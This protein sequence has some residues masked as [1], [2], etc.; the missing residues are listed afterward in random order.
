MKKFLFYISI[1]IIAGCAS[2]QKSM[3]TAAF[4]SEGGTRGKSLSTELETQDRVV[5]FNGSLSI[6][7]EDTDVSAEKCADIAKAYE[8][9]VVTSSTDR[10]VF[11]VKAERFTGAMDEVAKLGKV[12]YRNIHGR[13]VTEQYRDTEIRL[14]NKLKAR[15]RY[16]QLLARAETVEATL[17][18]EKELERLN[19]EIESYKGRL[20]R[21]SHLASYSTIT[22]DFTERTRYGPLGWVFYGAWHAIKWLFVWE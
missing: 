22:V 4:T 14:E 8:G 19:G 20:Q 11:R 1:L 5:I 3:N 10:V 17:Q 13:D 9:Y 15:E 2:P 21:L 6:R 16:L 12:T 7:V 18:V